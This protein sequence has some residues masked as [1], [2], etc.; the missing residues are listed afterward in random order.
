MFFID[1]FK[2]GDVVQGVYLCKS[3]TSGK[4][5]NGNEYESVVL[6]DKTGSIDAKI[7]EPNSPGI[8]EFEPNDYV[9][10]K[11]HVNVYNKA[12]QLKI[13]TARKADPG[14]YVEAD[15]VPTSRF[16]TSVMM[17]ELRSIIK[18]VKNPYLNKLL[19]SF[20]KEDKEM[21]RRFMTASAAKSVHHGFVG[22]LLEHTLSVARLCTK[23]C[24]N[25]D[26][27]SYDILVTSA[28]LHDIGKTREIS[29]FPLND[30]TDEGNM[31]GHLV[32]GYGMVKERIAAIDGFPASLAHQ[33]EH[34]ILS[35]HGQ[36]EFGSPKKPATAEAYALAAAD[37][38]DAHLETL[39]ELFETKNTNTWLGYNKWLETNVRRTEI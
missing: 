2:E 27:L 22:G 18:S 4:S 19:N 13:D 11:G 15:Y 26:F 8:K 37:N 28:M 6:I 12:F 23:M 3:K 20:F 17:E 7:W 24:E 33:I 38:L 32:I 16:D 29:A 30:Y 5:K 34:C 35:H 25:Y 31:I 36:L 1:D 39:R 10:V 14:E 9:M 21:V